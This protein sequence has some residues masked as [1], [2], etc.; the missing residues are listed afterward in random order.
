M[1]VK[2]IIIQLCQNKNILE[3]CIS[4]IIIVVKNNIN[5]IG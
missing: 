4:K 2:N 5:T 1:Y 3:K